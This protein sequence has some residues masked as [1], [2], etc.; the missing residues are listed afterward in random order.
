MTIIYKNRAAKNRLHETLT[1]NYNVYQSII[2]PNVYQ[3]LFD[4][5]KLDEVQVT[6]KGKN[7]IHRNK[8]VNMVGSRA[9]YHLDDTVCVFE[10][11]ELL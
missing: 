9:V 3:V 6:L 1:N 5:W 11:D 10:P 4:L 7:S 2:N 8:G